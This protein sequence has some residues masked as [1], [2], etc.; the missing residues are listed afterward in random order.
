MSFGQ[1]AQ[2]GG[3]SS[4]SAVQ[5]EVRKAL[6][7]GYPAGAGPGGSGAPLVYQDLSST[8]SVLT[9]T[10]VDI[11]F[12]AALAREQATSTVKEYDK[13]LTYG[14]QQDNAIFAPERSSGIEDSAGYIKAYAYLKWLNKR[15]SV[16]DTA[17]LVNSIVDM[18]T[19]ETMTQSMYMLRNVEKLLFTGDS[20]L[21]PMAWDGL[22][23]FLFNEAPAANRVDAKGAPLS[24]L[25]VNQLMT[26]LRSA[27]NHAMLTDMYLSFQALQDYNASFLQTQGRTMLDTGAGGGVRAISADF[28]AFN[29]TSGSIKFTPNTFIDTGAN[30]LVAPAQ[31]GANAPGAPTI[32]APTSAP[33]TGS[34]FGG[35]D[36][37]GYLYAVQAAN[38]LGLSPVVQ[39][40][41]SPLAVAAGD[42]PTFTITPSASGP[43][44]DYFIIFRSEK[45]GSFASKGEI[46]RV[47][48]VV[49]MDGSQSPVVFIDANIFRPNTTCAYIF[50]NTID[51][52]SWCELLSLA[53][54]DLAKT[55]T[56]KDFMLNMVATPIWKAQTKMG[57]IYNIGA[58]S[59]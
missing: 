26:T 21:D 15:G 35:S 18:E 43:A 59:Y 33:G 37:G 40:N 50:Q 56:S 41:T 20:S 1:L 9:N 53:K 44:A 24:W 46:K 19:Q 8:I 45:D 57:V 29:S 51:V 34:Q 2:L 11:R 3:L 48:N 52:M 6:S 4:G 58:A 5:D 49:A 31:Q 12:Y 16:T 27:P 42:T 54:V 55:Q 25:K 32:A 14:F 23:T 36:A 38:R 30:G 10:N 28:A 7:A 47:K 17:R 39:V 22:R 13:L